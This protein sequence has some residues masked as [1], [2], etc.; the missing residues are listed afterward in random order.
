VPA[1]QGGVCRFEVFR[2]DGA[3]FASQGGESVH[4][5]VAGSAVIGLG[6][7]RGVTVRPGLGDGPLGRGCPWGRL[8]GRRPVTAGGRSR[9]CHVPGGGKYDKASAETRGRAARSS[10]RCRWAD[11]QAVVEGPRNARLDLGPGAF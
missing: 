8:F 1:G 2:S 10:V 4:R 5:E 11:V 6:P 3:R 9:A 7:G